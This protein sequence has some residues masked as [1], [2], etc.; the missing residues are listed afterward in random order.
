MKQD[1]LTYLNNILFPCVVFSAVTGV[2]TG[3][4]IFL[5]RWA[6][7]WVATWS[8]EGY[9]WVRSNPKWFI[10][11]VFFALV[12]G[13][14]SW[15]FW[16]FLP[17]GRGGGIPASIG[18]VRGILSFRWISV[19]ISTF[20]SSLV[21]YLGGIPLG[22]EGPS[23]QMGTAV[24]KGTVRLLGRRH[25]AWDR[26]VMTGGA[27]AGFAAATGAP[28]TGIL[29][30]FEEAHQ[31]FSPMLLMVS[32]MTT[33]S[34]SL[35]SKG[36][37]S[38]TETSWDLFSFSSGET[39]PLRYSWA[40]LLAGM[41]CGLFAFIF[42]KGYDWVERLLRKG[43]IPSVLRICLLF[44][45]VAVVGF[46]LGETTGSGHD[47]IESVFHGHGVWYLL[48]AFL[49]IRALVLLFANNLGVTGGLFIPSLAFGALLGALCAR[50]M[51]FLGILPEAYFSV[52]VMVGMCAFLGASARTPLMAIAFSMEALS[53]I[54][55]VL[56]VVL[57]VCFAYVVIELTGAECFVDTVLFQ[58]IRTASHG[59]TEISVEEKF[60]VQP[61]SFVIGKEVRD[62]LW[63]PRC[64]V[65]SID[66]NHAAA[67]GG[68]TLSQ[69]DVLHLHYQTVS[70]EETYGEI[71]A[72]LG[73]QNEKINS[74][75]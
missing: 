1:R 38:L 63:P 14:I 29:F 37:F 40:P 66:R 2:V 49:L 41:V 54:N 13:G 35:T 36:L 48:L 9:A 74:P 42:T 62:I 39:L 19:L 7:S 59:K 53:G 50:G 22:T 26:Y 27:G 52:M 4:L 18:W 6:V 72:L 10:L 61:H 23:V 64:Q 30:A 65:L 8:S 47:L 51:I 73:A 5:F 33:I 16:R 75:S 17:D 71:E 69:G 70:P 25:P 31:R 60:T 45:F 68:A 28:L 44:V 12:L 15:I 24:G 46:F 21:T 67:H 55:N 57:G 32:S 58:K 34:A 20:F 56:P 11:I 43:K 3:G